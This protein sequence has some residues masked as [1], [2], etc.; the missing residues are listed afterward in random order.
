MLT[1]KYEKD[2]IK[3]VWKPE[4]CYHSENCT[5]GLPEVFKPNEKPWIQVD[6]ASRERIVSQVKKC[7]SGALSIEGD[8]NT[9]KE[10][11]Q[12]ALTLIET[13]K[14]GPVLVKGNLGLKIGDGETDRLSQDR[15]ALCRCGSS[16]KKPF[17]DGSHTK[18]DF[19]AD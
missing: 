17:C 16:S 9:E 12:E 18:V 5:K 6:E 11:P 10:A 1:R 14:N 19:K 13:V 4:L 3:V 7:P 15:I 8:S 2:G